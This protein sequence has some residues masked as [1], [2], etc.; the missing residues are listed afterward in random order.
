[1]EL[2]DI[3]GQE[4]YFDLNNITEFVKINE[5][6]PKDLEDLLSKKNI[7]NEDNEIKNE[8]PLQGPLIDM[9]KWD[10]TK[11]MIETILSEN[12]IID[13]A[14]GVTKMSQQLS[15]PFRLSFNTLMKNKLIKTNK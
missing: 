13:E 4:Y 3:A 15:I 12:G 1:M 7:D 10:L 14:M 2:F 8:D 11:A 6:E 9:T 5:N